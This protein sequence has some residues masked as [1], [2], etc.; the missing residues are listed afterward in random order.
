MNAGNRAQQGGPA[1]TLGRLTLGQLDL[2]P[3]QVEQLAGRRLAQQG[4]QCF[5]QRFDARRRLVELQLPEGTDRQLAGE[6]QPL[7]QSIQG[8]LILQTSLQQSLLEQIAVEGIGGEGFILGQG[9]LLLTELHPQRAL[10]ETSHRITKETQQIGQLQLR[11]LIPLLRQRQG[12][13]EE[14]GRR[15]LG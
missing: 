6:L 5:T 9:L 8:R 4:L 1:A 14:G 15:L 7:A 13:G 12:C 2:R 10:E 11:L 3:A